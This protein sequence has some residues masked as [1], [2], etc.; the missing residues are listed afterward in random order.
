MR[1][2]TAFQETTAIANQAENAR[3][4]YWPSPLGLENNSQQLFLNIAQKM[5]ICIGCNI[6]PHF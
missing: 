1:Q 6:H 3:E 4:E 2:T 5:Q